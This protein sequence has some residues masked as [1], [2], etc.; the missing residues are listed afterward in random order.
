MTAKAGKHYVLEEHAI[1]RLILSPV[2][3]AALQTVLVGS[4][5]FSRACV[6]AMIARPDCVVGV[7][8]FIVALNTVSLYV[9]VNGLLFLLF[10]RLR[11]CHSPKF[12]VVQ[13]QATTTMVVTLLDVLSWFAWL[14]DLCLFSKTGLHMH[15]FS[16]PWSQVW[17][18]TLGVRGQLLVLVGA[19][20][21]SS[22]LCVYALQSFI[23]S[24]QRG[25]AP[26]LKAVLKLTLFTR[27]SQRLFASTKR[28]LLPPSTLL[29]L[30]ALA[31]QIVVS[32]GTAMSDPILKA[33]WTAMPFHIL[34]TP[35]RISEEAATADAHEV[36]GS[37]KDPPARDLDVAEAWKTAQN[38]VD[39]RD[40]LRG[41]CPSS[42]DTKTRATWNATTLESVTLE[43]PGV[44]PPKMVAHQPR[45]V[46]LII[47]DSL[48]AREFLQHVPDANRKTSAH[49]RVDTHNRLENLGCTLLQHH[50]SGSSYTHD[51]LY[52]IF[53][54]VPPMQYTDKVYPWSV[55]VDS[56]RLAGYK[57]AMFSNGGEHGYDYCKN[58]SLRD[59]GGTLRF[60][61]MEAFRNDAQ[62][63]D[64]ALAWLQ[65]QDEQKP[66]FLS[67][68]L[69]SPHLL[70]GE[71]RH[72]EFED[73]VTRVL[74]HVTNIMEHNAKIPTRDGLGP[75]VVVTGDH[76]S[77]VTGVDSDCG[78]FCQTHG[79]G[80]F[81]NHATEQLAHVPL[82]LCLQGGE[83]DS[84]SSRARQMI[85]AAQVLPI[86]SSVDLMPSLMD[87][88]QLDPLP[89]TQ[90]WSTGNSWFR[91]VSSSDDASFVFSLS[92]LN[93]RQDIAIINNRFARYHSSNVGCLPAD[94][95][96]SCEQHSRMV[97]Y[98]SWAAGSTNTSLSDETVTPS[99]SEWE[100]D[101]YARLVHERLLTPVLNRAALPYPPSPVAFLLATACTDDNGDTFC[102]ASTK[103]A[104]VPTFTLEPCPSGFRVGD[105][106]LL[107]FLWTVWPAG[108]VG[109]ATKDVFFNASWQIDANGR[110]VVQNATSKHGALVLGACYNPPN[111]TPSL[112]PMAGEDIGRCTRLSIERPWILQD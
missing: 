11:R 40:P 34:P 101:D 102:V 41:L 18:D 37:V 14:L 44:P 91:P 103:G 66:F 10:K 3:M 77:A 92:R 6:V 98:P 45:S 35:L 16:I 75:L 90:Y 25:T 12:R 89:P 71:G 9:V 97:T 87:M 85:H 56:F 36:T 4:Q 47:V 105:K 30:G 69:E 82:W 22:V 84:S 20:L 108:R 80:T 95:F 5:P 19:C 49:F 79:Y 78:E 112:A 31:W 48:P 53:H 50:H 57:T 28:H 93:C 83:D 39:W 104:Q 74:D 26:G 55:P 13:A 109:H 29:L 67:I 24:C 52:S 88:I 107:P 81:G 21:S 106:A 70:Y 99:R 58:R 76:G 2:C 8:A 17:T 38:V 43:R 96:K 65:Q 62:V 32:Q 33:G 42:N 1:A 94:D 59:G 61:T 15:D 73:S 111:A 46:V 100:V 54:A 23:S 64:A 68:Y 72:G 51:A 63:T 27:T 110:H 7:G 86:T 60:E